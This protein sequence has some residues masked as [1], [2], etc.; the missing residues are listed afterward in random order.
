M[1]ISTL[2]A[3]ETKEM[4]RK[5]GALRKGKPAPSTPF[6]QQ[7][8]NLPPALD[9]NDKPV[10]VSDQEAREVHEAGYRNLIGE[11]LWPARNAYPCISHGVGKLS[12][13]VHRPS[14]GAWYSALYLLHFL[15]RFREDGTRYRS[16]GNILSLGSASA[17]VVYGSCGCLFPYTFSDSC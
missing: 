12:K 16:D 2:S 9:E 4:W 17:V 10:G 3:F 11:L 8:D 1:E 7:A 13:C 15:Y 6:P 14:W 5:Y